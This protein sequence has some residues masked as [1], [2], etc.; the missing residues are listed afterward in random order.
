MYEQTVNIL[1]VDDRPENLLALETALEPL[2]QTLVR[3]ASGAEAL[4]QVLRQ[5]FAVI[6]L[7]VQMPEMDGF[8]AA[9][10]IRERDQSKHIPIIF[11]TAIGKSE[12][13][14][15]KGYSVGAVDYVF[16]PFTPEILRAKVAVFVD[17]H[18]M[19]R[20][21]EQQAGQL[22]DYNRQLEMTNLQLQ[23][24]N[25]ELESFSYAV[26][27]DLRAPLR[28][29]AGF[30]DALLEEYADRL[31]ETALGYLRRVRA[32]TA[33]MGE[34]IEGLL[35]L[36]RLSRGELMIGKVE[37]SRI[38]REIADELAR[39]EPGRNVE[40]VIAPNL[41]AGGDGRLLRVVLQNL[42][43]NAWKYT[44]KH[45]KA[46]IEFGV[47]SDLGS[48]ISDFG[49]EI[50]DPKS[51]IPDLQ[52]RIYF[53]KDDGAGFDMAYAK[54]LFVPFQRLHNQTE[55][56]GIGIGLA[57]VQRIVARHGGRVWAEGEVERGATFYFT[58]GNV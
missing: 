31:D 45:P 16:K 5:E 24:A 44:A 43:G 2:G 58:L 48:R 8:E 6:L 33:I 39:G 10:L 41:S 53:V 52:S 21:I 28:S 42:M 3:A 15:F 27:H 25:R 4:R 38:A 35:D 55:F 13:E 46:R 17:L 40:F 32:S 23:A 22:E 30:G 57:T 19:R 49:S 51:E 26:S 50:R 11:L 7:D 1:L 12:P 47:I 29:I 56:A 9:S 36:S 37:L 34:M 20:R 18:Q 14:V 54:N